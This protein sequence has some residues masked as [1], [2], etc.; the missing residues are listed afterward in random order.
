MSMTAELKVTKQL[1]NAVEIFERMFP[2]V[3]ASKL[4]LFDEFLKHIPETKNQYECKSGIIRAIKNDISDFRA[5]IMDP[6]FD[7]KGKLCYKA[8]MK[9]A[10]GKSPIWWEETFKELMPSKNS[11]IGDQCHRYAFLGVIIKELV[12]KLNYTV[13]QAWR[14][15]C[16]D[17]IDLGN[18]GESQNS[19]P[20]FEPTGSRAIYIW[21]DLGNTCKIVKSSDSNFLLFGDDYMSDGK[22]CSLSATRDINLSTYNYNNSV[23][24]LVLDV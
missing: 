6:S 12:E 11:R 19:I 16:D 18:Y 22:T 2:V 3:N 1:L 23:G 20:D 5:P 9:P 8:G 17:S 13:T 15:V 10:I 21:C 14:A 4:C 7:E 24:W